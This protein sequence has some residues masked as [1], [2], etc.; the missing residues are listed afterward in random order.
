VSRGKLICCFVVSLLIVGITLVTYGE[1]V[2]NMIMSRIQNGTMPEI[3]HSSEGWG[4]NYEPVENFLIL[5][6]G[7]VV[8]FYGVC[9]F[10]K[11]Q[12]L[13]GGLF[14]LYLFGY[15]FVTAEFWQLISVTLIPMVLLCGIAGYCLKNLKCGEDGEMRKVDDERIYTS[16]S[17]HDE[18][19]A[20][21]KR[22]GEDEIP[23]INALR[24]GTGTIARKDK[25]WGSVPGFFAKLFKKK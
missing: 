19:N 13:G 24:G 25:S 2:E 18:L 17:L 14:G 7:F 8:L 11:S 4:F 10:A 1:A 23:A 22:K 9:F 20:E 16:K 5:S 6:V 15:L 21:R 12:L 3:Y